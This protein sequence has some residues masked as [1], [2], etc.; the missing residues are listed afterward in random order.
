VLK[1]TLG[2]ALAG[3]AACLLTAGTAQALPITWTIDQSASQVAVSIDEEVSNSAE[4]QGTVVGDLTPGSSI[5]ASGG[6]IEIVDDVVILLFGGLPLTGSGLG[7]ILTGPATPILAG[8]ADLDGWAL[9]L[10]QGTLVQPDLELNLDLSVSPFDFV[11]PSTL[12]TITDLGGGLYEWEIPVSATA[13]VDASDI[14]PGLF[15]PVV[16]S[17]NILLTGTP[18]PEPGTALILLGGLTALAVRRRLA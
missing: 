9:T 3:M 14:L 5:S 7:G 8:V 2:L 16:V 18:V 13:L 15:I 10:N 11:F 12:S 1:R 17:G 6:S 4:L